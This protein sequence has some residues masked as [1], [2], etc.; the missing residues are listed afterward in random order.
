MNSS[1]KKNRMAIKHFYKSPQN[2]TTFVFSPHKLLIRFSAPFRKT[3]FYVL[4]NYLSVYILKRTC[5]PCYFS[6]SNSFNA[7]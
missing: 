3:S 5:L 2:P 1:S 7:D 4:S 6:L